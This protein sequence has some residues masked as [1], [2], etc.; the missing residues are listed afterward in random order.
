MKFL[1]KKMAVALAIAVAITAIW[2]GIHFGV[3]IVYD[4]EIPI[5]WAAT[6]ALGTWAS[7]IVPIF[8]V[9][10]TAYV[11]ERMKNDREMVS[12]SNLELLKKF[13]A[14]TETKDTGE[15][16]LSHIQSYITIAMMSATQDIA[17]YIKKDSRETMR[18]LEELEERGKIRFIGGAKER[19]AC[20]GIWMNQKS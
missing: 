1:K 19:E 5:D 12:Q 6:T 11:T 4:P 18:L 10:L 2:T 16:L 13:E 7:A 9:F 8:L 14:E 20:A 3:R 17:D 15:Q